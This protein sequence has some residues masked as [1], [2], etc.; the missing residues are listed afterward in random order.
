MGNKEESEKEALIARI[1]S[2]I[3]EVRTEKG[4]TQEQLAE[5]AKVDHKYLSKVENG[6]KDN[7]SIGYLFDVA[8][9]LGIDFRDL[10]N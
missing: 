2:K 4:F 3:R 10:L 5:A 7:I 6:R 8:T 9:A 1:G